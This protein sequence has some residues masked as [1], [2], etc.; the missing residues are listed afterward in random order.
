MV[1]PIDGEP[2]GGEYNWFIRIFN[3]GPWKVHSRPSKEDQFL[4]DIEFNSSPSM[5]TSQRGAQLEN[6]EIAAINSV[7]GRQGYYKEKIQEI[8]KDAEKLEY[9]GIKGFVNIIRAQRRGMISSEVLDTAKFANIY[10]RITQ[11][12]I[13]AKRYAENSL[14][15]DIKSDIRMREYEKIEKDK[16]QKRGNLDKLYKD[17]GLVNLLPVDA[18]K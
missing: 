10:S 5:N 12:Y 4:I 7:I 15:D 18:F 3:R 6:H 16:D 14:P 2:V 1:N 11:A 8:M 13:A 9:D 17:A